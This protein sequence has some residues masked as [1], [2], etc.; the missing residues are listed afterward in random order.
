MTCPNCGS[1]VISANKC[2]K[3]KMDVVLYSGTIK[4][5]DIL[6]NRGLAKAKA[7]DLTNAIENLTKSVQINKNNVFA[8]NLLGLLLL[9]V[10]HVG[11]AIKEW[12]ISQ[13]LLK[14]NNP[15]S[16]YLDIASNNNDLLDN[17]NDAV[18]MYNQA[19]EFIHLKNDDMAMI[20]LKKA[21]EINPKFIDALNLLSFCF[22]IKRDIDRAS[23]TIDRVLAM[24]ANNTIALTYYSEINPGQI[25]PAQNIRKAQLSAKPIIDETSPQTTGSQPFTYNKIPINEKAKTNFHFAEIV[26]FIIGAACMLAVIYILVIPTITRR[27]NE[28]ERNF[29]Q[30]L[31]ESWD[32]YIYALEQKDI[33]IA[34]LQTEVNGMTSGFV[35]MEL[36]LDIQS[37]INL[38]LNAYSLYNERRYVASVDML[39]N[40]DITGLPPDIQ[41]RAETIMYEARPLAAREYFNSGLTAYNNN[42]YDNALTEFERSLS[43]IMETAD[44]YENLL[45]Y[46]GSL[47]AHLNMNL[48]AIEVLEALKDK[49]PNHPRMDDVNNIIAT[50]NG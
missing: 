36:E 1:D 4:I 42:D 31:D 32:E 7:G 49:N 30:Q 39:G 2:T 9:E 21:V 50:I 26:S 47:Y 11:G 27:S 6:Y 37:R 33:E 25:K 3:C 40:I 35:E 38:I 19:L 48:K 24:D 18:L 8:R 13:S 14:D 17:L 45:F 16:L 46:L 23:S 41:D 44:E 28:M 5:S 12:V 34:N 15:A 29:R 43:L 22:L 10:G 20:Q